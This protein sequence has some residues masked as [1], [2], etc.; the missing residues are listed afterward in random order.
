MIDKIFQI[1]EDVRYVAIY[2]DGNLRTQSK[3]TQKVQA[4]QNLINMKSY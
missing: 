4:V 2:Q 3:I 1:S